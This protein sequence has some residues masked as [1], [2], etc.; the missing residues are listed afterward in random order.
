M[1]NMVPAHTLA[2]VLHRDRPRVNERSRNILEIEAVVMIYR[3]PAAR[4]HC[5]RGASRTTAQLRT[6]W[7]AAADEQSRNVIETKVLARIC[8]GPGSLRREVQ[9]A[10]GQVMRFADDL[11]MMRTVLTPPKQGF[12]PQENRTKPECFRKQGLYENMSERAG[13]AKR[14]VGEPGFNRPTVRAGRPEFRYCSKLDVA[15]PSW[16]LG[17]GWKPVLP[18]KLRQQAN[19]VSIL[20]AS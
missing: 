9:P 6:L 18:S 4:T 12:R 20:P 17:V 10:V 7:L 11:G 19:F 15:P 14:R 16:R 13:G 5:R 3:R 2:I 1:Q 8:R